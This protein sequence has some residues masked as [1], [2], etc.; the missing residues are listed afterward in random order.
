MYSCWGPEAKASAPFAVAVKCLTID[1]LCICTFV[2]NGNERLFIVIHCHC[3]CHWRWLVAG[4]TCLQ[5][6]SNG[7]TSFLRLPIDVLIAV[8]CAPASICLTEIMQMPM[9]HIHLLPKSDTWQ[10]IVLSIYLIDGLL[11]AGR[12]SSALA[13]ELCLSCANPSMCWLL[14]Y[15]HLLPFIQQKLCRC[16]WY[17]YT[18]IAAVRHVAMYFFSL[19]TAIIVSIYLIDGL[20]HEGHVSS[21]LALGLSCANPSIFDCCIM[22]TCFHLFN[23]NSAD[24]HDAYTFITKVRP[25]IITFAK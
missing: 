17:I 1:L 23:R 6:V 8:L 11:R 21:A 2:V 22:C 15:V 3:H 25:M 12:V 16:P 19:F 14:C 10:C 9:T 4:G 18:F 24:A 5:C 13:M 7:V 20:V